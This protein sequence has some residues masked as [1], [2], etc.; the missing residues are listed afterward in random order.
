MRKF[1]LV[2]AGMLLIVTSLL[3]QNYHTV[4]GKVTDESGAGL[5][6]V[7]VSLPGGKSGTVTDSKGEFSITVPENVKSL[8]ASFVGYESQTL[9]I[10]GSSAGSITLLPDAKAIS[11]V[12]VIGYGTQR[13]KDVTGGIVSIKGG[14]VAELPVQSFEAGLGGRAAGVQITVPNG[15]VN[16]PPVFRIRGANSIS[17]SAYPLI[18]IDGVPTFSGDVGNSNAPLNPLS[19]I[20]PSDIASIDIAKDAAATAI[21]GSRAANG[22]VFV[23]TKKGKAG[24]PKVAYDGWVGTMKPTRLPEVL[25]SAQYLEI[26]NEGLKNAGSTDV[27][28]PNQDASGKTID[29]KWMDVVYRDRTISQSHSVNISGGNESTSYYFSA[30]Y[31][32]QQ[33]ILKR[34]E[35]ARKNLLF[36]IDQQIGKAFTIGAR[37]NYSN[38]QSLI[39]GSSGSLEGVFGIF[40]QVPVCAGI[41]YKWFRNGWWEK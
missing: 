5:P 3:A 23:T 12:V 8:K 32:K 19:S 2:L 38:E 18:V 35:F 17:M 1:L 15:V 40:K 6:G 9:T 16:N 11:E 7:S 4:K 13:K 10:K 22:V 21:Y 28:V 27:Y 20:N 37:I 36:N 26:K 30:G 31:T 14:A 24:R 29:T 34:N 41:Q 25:N 39:S 33:G